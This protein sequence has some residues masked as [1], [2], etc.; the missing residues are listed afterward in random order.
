MATI[1]CTMN[2]KHRSKRPLRKYT[3]K[4]GRKCYGCK[5]ETV[6]ISRIFDPDAYVIQVIE[7][8]QMAHCNFY[9]PDGT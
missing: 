4:D 6:T 9:E 1:V 8:E 2:C 7:E 5:L 3:F